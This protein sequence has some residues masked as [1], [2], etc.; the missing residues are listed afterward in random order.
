VIMPTPHWQRTIVVAVLAVPLL[1]VVLL[2]APTWLVWPFLSAERRAAV[3]EFLDHLVD[4]VKALMGT[5][6]Q[7]QPHESAPR[8]GSGSATG[9]GSDPPSD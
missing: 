6:Q 9:A 5:D 1:M 8:R 4:W 3:L 2:S 7:S